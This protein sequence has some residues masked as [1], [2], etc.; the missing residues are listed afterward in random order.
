MLFIFDMGGVVTSTFNMTSMYDFLGMSEQQFKCFYKENN[1]NLYDAVSK[2]EICVKE[3]WQ[4]FNKRIE[5]KGFPK[6][7]YDL[8]RL[9]F[10]PV[11]NEKTVSLINA[12][13]K[14]NRV[15]CGTNTLQSHWENHLERGDYAFFHK[16]YASNKIGVI[17]PDTEFFDL[18]L[19][20]EGF[21]AKETFFTDDRIEN[22]EAA[23]S[24][25]INATLFTSAENLYKEWEKYI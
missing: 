6:V 25:G 18:I 15:V 10:N 20:A 24:V 9:C 8:F 5:G 22:I 3:F 13:K 1:Y 16:T 23:K 21:S 19:K 7:K 11:T 2:G 12:L 17:K 14:N 4:E